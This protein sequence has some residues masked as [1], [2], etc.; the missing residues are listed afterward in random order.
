MLGRLT[1]TALDCDKLTK[2]TMTKGS[3]KRDSTP[4]PR[5][6]KEM[7]S[8]Q[9]WGESGGWSSRSSDSSGRTEQPLRKTESNEAGREKRWYKVLP[10][11]HS[12]WRGRGER[13]RES[14]NGQRGRDRAWELLRTM[15]SGS[16]I[17]EFLYLFQKEQRELTR[18]NEQKPS[19][20]QGKLNALGNGARAG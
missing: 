6:Q 14:A 15:V 7:E 1:A 4:K 12:G 16:L 3:N 11:T 17:G 19:S 18:A 2:L 20:I 13:E 10:A 8:L 9:M 5:R